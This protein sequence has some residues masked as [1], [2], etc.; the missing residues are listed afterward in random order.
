MK[1]STEQLYPNEGK[2]YHDEHRKETEV[3]EGKKQ[4][5]QNLQDKLNT[6]SKRKQNQATNDI[7]S[8]VIQLPP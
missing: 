2:E 6:C 5:H 3:E 8:L 4:L 1:G 7:E